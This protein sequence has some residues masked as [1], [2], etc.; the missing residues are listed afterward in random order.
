MYFEVTLILGLVSS[1]SAAYARSAIVLDPPFGPVDFLPVVVC[2]IAR[3]N[4]VSL[5]SLVVFQTF[6]KVWN[7]VVPIG[8]YHVHSVYFA[9]TS[10]NFVLSLRLIRYQFVK[11]FFS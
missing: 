10:R 1:R 11:K 8:L 3:F 5:L 2:E 6:L 4:T 9:W 7:I